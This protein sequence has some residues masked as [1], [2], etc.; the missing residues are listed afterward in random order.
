MDA[1]TVEKKTVM[2]IAVA[3]YQS[4]D[5][6]LGTLIAGLAPLVLDVAADLKSK[7]GEGIS[8]VLDERIGRSDDETIE[9]YFEHFE[10]V[11]PT[12]AK[13]LL[14]HAR[15][16]ILNPEWTKEEV[17]AQMIEMT[18]YR[19]VMS[20]PHTAQRIFASEFM[21][22]VLATAGQYLKTGECGATPEGKLTIEM[23]DEA[24]GILNDHRHVLPVPFTDRAID[25]L[26]EARAEG[27]S[28]EA[29]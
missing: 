16:F 1:T 29:S 25:Y 12:W 7:D 9:R 19:G 26:E 3:D 14:E 2:Q 8:Q 17:G 21:S 4:G 23:A 22:I 13:L 28:E 24:I 18:K 15:E 20:V 27:I 11:E 5:E 10:K 6:Q